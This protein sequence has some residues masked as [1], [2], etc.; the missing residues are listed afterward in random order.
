MVGHVEAVCQNVPGVIRL[1]CWI[2]VLNGCPPRSTK[3]LSGFWR[4]ML[5]PSENQMQ[6][7]KQPWAFWAPDWGQVWQ[8][9]T[10]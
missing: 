10:M 1:C 7:L 9:W 5:D 4:A 3:I 8:S 2:C 6:G